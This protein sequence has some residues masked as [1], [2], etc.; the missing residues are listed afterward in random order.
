MD[1]TIQQNTFMERLIDEN[2]EIFVFDEVEYSSKNYAQIEHLNENLCSSNFSDG[3]PTVDNQYELVDPDGSG[4]EFIEE[5]SS[6][7]EL[8]DNY[9]MNY[10][11][12]LTVKDFWN[13]PYCLYKAKQIDFLH[14]HIVDTHASVTCYKCQEC[15]YAHAQISLVMAHYN[16]KHNKV[17]YQCP[18]CK[19]KFTTLWNCQGH[20]LTRHPDKAQKLLQILIKKKNLNGNNK[21]CPYCEFEVHS[22]TLL[23]RHVETIHSEVI[24]FKCLYCM[25]NNL[26]TDEVVEH[27]KD[28]HPDEIEDIE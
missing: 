17:K 7:E 20:I 13:C 25:Y 1:K 2:T 8:E 9:I 21:H 3:S 23:K 12:N 22:S 4:I 10:K 27:M 19:F 26:D 24:R 16:R 6:T 28:A 15:Q 18:D 14:S 5:Q 11:A